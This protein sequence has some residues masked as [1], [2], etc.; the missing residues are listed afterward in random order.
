MKPYV[1]PAETLRR[2]THDDSRQPRHRRPH[3]VVIG[4]MQH[5]FVP[6][7]RQAIAF[8]MRV[9]A[10][11]RARPVSERPG[12][13]AQLLL[14]VKLGRTAGSGGTMGSTTCTWRIS[15]TSSSVTPPDAE[16]ISF[17]SRSMLRPVLNRL[18]ENFSRS[19]CVWASPTYDMTLIVSSVSAGFPRFGTIADELKFQR[20]GMLLQILVD[21]VGIGLGE[22]AGLRRKPARLRRGP[23]RLAPAAA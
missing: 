23:C 22:F 18:D 2:P 17:F 21:T 8:Q 10:L 13:T 5:G 4:R 15:S 11:Q 19:C 20:P 1:N 6:D 16:R 3:L 12:A 9:V 14:E 7:R